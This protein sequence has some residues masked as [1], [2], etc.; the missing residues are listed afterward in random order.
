MPT[1]SGAA[2][3]S[4][5]IV[6]VDTAGTP[7]P[8]AGAH[9]RLWTRIVDV[10][11]PSIEA[12]FEVTGFTDELGRFEADVIAGI[13]GD[14]REYEVRVNPPANAIAA[15]KLDLIEVGAD[16]ADL[17]AIALGQRSTLTGVLVDATGKTIDG[18]TVT[19]VPSLYFLWSL[20]E[21]VQ[22]R[23]SEREAPSNVTTPDGTF[24]IWVDPAVAGLPASY[25]LDCEPTEYSGI[26]RWTA[27]AI[28][29]AMSRDLEIL[30][31]PD[32]AFVR[33]VV[34]DSQGE[35][36]PDAVVRVYEISQDLGA[37]IAENAPLDC[38][39]PAVLRASGR[40]DEFGEVRLVLPR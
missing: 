39:P 40:V 4:L 3:V 1:Y 24:T 14:P 18:V 6:H 15:A 11:D 29:G 32:G 30:Q 21:D 35:I 23:L 16:D 13:D 27:P 19:A 12:T 8:V 36:L 34:T 7:N 22:Q 28:D 20:E 31:L 38:Q 37:C 9:V 10:T 5:P 25:D 26:P 2:E 17:D 33:G